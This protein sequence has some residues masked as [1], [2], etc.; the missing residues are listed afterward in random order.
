MIKIKR[1]ELFKKFNNQ[2]IEVRPLWQ[3]GHLQN[4]LKKYQSYK[5]QNANKIVNTLCLPSSYFL[6][7]KQITKSNKMF[8]KINLIV[9][10]GGHA[11]TCLDVIHNLKKYRL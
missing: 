4:Y 1:E 5:I 3:L 7:E 6:T 11:N 2:N 10:C 8:R 9:G